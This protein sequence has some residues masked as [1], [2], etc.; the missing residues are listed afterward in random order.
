MEDTTDI[1]AAAMVEHSGEAS[2]L[3]KTL[4]NEKRLVICCLLLGHDHTVAELNAAL[5]LSQSALSQH[6]AVLREADVVHCRRDGQH[7][8]YSLSDGPALAVI[9]ALHASFCAP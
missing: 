6:L 2:G 4:A 1:D 8:S 9:R 3:L 5:D 7:M